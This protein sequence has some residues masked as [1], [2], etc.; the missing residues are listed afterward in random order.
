MKM[1]FKQFWNNCTKEQK[2]FLLGASWFVSTVYYV[3]IP[4]PIDLI[5]LILG[6]FCSYGIGRVMSGGW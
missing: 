5:F 4:S 2:Y 6:A 1:K 3:Y